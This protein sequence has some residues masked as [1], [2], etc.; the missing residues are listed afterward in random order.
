MDLFEGVDR[1]RNIMIAA[2]VVV[3]I[4]VIIYLYTADHLSGIVW[5]D[6]FTRA[7]TGT[8]LSWRPPFIMLKNGTEHVAIEAGAAAHPAHTVKALQIVE[9]I[10]TM[11]LGGG[12]KPK[13]AV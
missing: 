4:L 13:H 8:A 11:V 3:V 12:S 9:E 6:T 10:R 1:N 5:G 2:A 7:S